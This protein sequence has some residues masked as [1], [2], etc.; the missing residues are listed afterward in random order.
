MVVGSKEGTSER[1]W[2]LGTNQAVCGGSGHVILQL[3][4]FPC[5][6]R[7][8]KSVSSG[9]EIGSDHSPRA[10]LGRRYLA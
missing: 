3:A 6:L 5:R 8:N 9:L 2:G 10:P 7:R 1:V 4:H